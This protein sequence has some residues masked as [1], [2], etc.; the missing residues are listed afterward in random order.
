MPIGGEIGLRDAAVLNVRAAESI[1]LGDKVSV[2]ANVKLDGM[3]GE[4]VKAWL[5]YEGQQVDEKVIDV[6]DDPFRTEVRFSHIPPAHGIYSYEVRLAQ[7]EDELFP[8]NNAWRFETAVTDDRTNVLLVDSFPRWEFRYLR[9]LFYA[10]DK[11]VH[12]QYVLLAP[13]QI[14]GFPPSQPVAA[15]AA[16]PFGE[17]EAQILPQGREEWLKFDAIILGDIPPNALAAETWDDIEHCVA[18]RGALLVCIAGPRFMPHAFGD[19]RFLEMMPM[20]FDSR[21]EPYFGNQGGPFK[22]APTPEGLR[23][24]I[25]EQS[26]SPAINAQLWN[27]LPEAS[28]R[29]PVAGVKESA[30]VLA[31]AAPPSARPGDPPP[32]PS[33]MRQNALL[34]VQRYAT[35]RTAMLAFDQTWRL[36]YGVGDTLHHK[37]WGQMLRWGTGENL[38]AGTEHVRVG[39]DRLAYTPQDKITIM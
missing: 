24:L 16:R 33:F 30:E 8:N 5:Y 17:A 28:W 6:A 37:F 7:V 1:Y 3:R 22:I 12:L 23:H 10:R 2:R 4:Q 39:S 21:I 27:A 15:S 19:E 26:P 38:R 31:Y 11:S 20:E 32:D 36:R 13:D 29:H 14:E 34:A 9:N 25:M 35:G 18:D